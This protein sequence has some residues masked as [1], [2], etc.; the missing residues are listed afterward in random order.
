MLWKFDWDIASKVNVILSAGV[1]KGLWSRK[2]EGIGWK[3]SRTHPKTKLF[4]FLNELS[5]N[6]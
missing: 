4:E 3:G 1:E 5:V 2:E 6:Q